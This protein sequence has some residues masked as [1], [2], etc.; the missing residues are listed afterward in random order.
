M[1]RWAQAVSLDVWLQ[2]QLG[3]GEG[4]EA[5]RGQGPGPGR[6]SQ[7]WA[8]PKDQPS[9]PLNTLF[10]DGKQVWGRGCFSPHLSP[11]H[12]GCHSWGAG[13]KGGRRVK[14][15]RG[16]H[17]LLGLQGSSS[18]REPAVGLFQGI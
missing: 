7:S 2:G 1:L 11:G 3:M 5:Q 17:R 12:G 9:R 16:A 6:S 4:S 13:G 8:A 10:Q 15:S 18:L 14:D